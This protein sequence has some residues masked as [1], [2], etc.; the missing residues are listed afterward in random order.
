MTEGNIAPK[1]C[2]LGNKLEIGG[3]QGLRELYSSSIFYYAR[4]FFVAWVE[5]C[6]HVNLSFSKKITS[7]IRKIKCFPISGLFLAITCFQLN[8]FYNFASFDLLVIL[9]SNIVFKLVPLSEFKNFFLF[10][11]ILKLILRITI[12]S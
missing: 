1:I 8:T 4:I 2:K 9:I 6:V 3:E 5:Y 12:T 11:Q 7:F 10:L